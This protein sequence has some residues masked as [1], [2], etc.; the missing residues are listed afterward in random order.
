[1]KTLLADAGALA[2]VLQRDRRYLHANPEI[3]HDLDNTVAYVKKRLTEMGYQ[4]QDIGDHGVVAVAG[5][6]KPGKCILLRAD[7]DAL[8]LVEQTDE[9][10]RSENGYMHACGHDLHMS[11]LLG[12][13][14]LLKDREDSLT[15]QVKLFFQPAEET[16]T[17][18]QN[19]IDAGVLENPKVDG[20]IALHADSPC[21]YRPGTLT[22]HRPG[23]ASA[24]CDRYR[25]HIQGTGGH[26]AK[27]HEAVDPINVGAHIHTALQEI[28]S[29][30]V[31]ATEA[32][33]L[34]QGVFHSGEAPN[35]IPDTAYLEGTLRCYDN[36][37][38]QQVLKRM[39]EIV[40]H[41]GK[42]FRADATLEIQGGCAPIDNDPK[43]FDQ[44]AGYLADLLG[45]DGLD[46]DGE[47]SQASED[48]SN[49]IQHVPGVLLF[50]TA[51]DTE[52]GYDSFMHHPKVR[53]DERAMPN[54]AAAMAAMAIRW[55][56]EEE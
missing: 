1:M 52:D 27:P 49:I 17:G 4:P 28:L 40:H 30:E 41:I 6:G 23:I 29:R 36:A 18:A 7:M 12:A 51:G 15:G 55:L 8:P 35:I 53:F 25:I 20:A 14:Q 45:E 26:G 5:A 13:A 47:V 19:A 50:V 44:L 54:G 2:P 42:A 3:G 9:P 22:M 43:M 31:P 39:G 24:S 37:L 32:V 56:A 16:L 34:T 46:I 10:F 38:R 33:V 48:F 21:R 11:M